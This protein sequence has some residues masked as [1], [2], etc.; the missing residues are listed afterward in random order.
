MSSALFRRLELRVRESRAALALR[1][2]PLAPRF[3]RRHGDWN[4]RPLTL[5]TEVLEGAG[6]SLRMIRVESVDAVQSTTMVFLPPRRSGHAIFVADLLSFAGVLGAVIL[7]VTPKGTTAPRPELASARLRLLESC[8]PRAFGDA[9]AAALFSTEAVFAKPRP[10]GGRQVVEAF[11]TYLAAFEQNVA[12][13]VSSDEAAASEDRFLKLL[14]S[15]KRQGLILSKLFGHDFVDEF[16]A[17]AF[18]APRV[19]RQPTEAA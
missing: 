2:V 13:R 15:V 3:A 7:D 1:P 11:E 5:T 19:V 6:M 9:D 8:T 18:C 4:G 16:F 17:E 10:D 12:V 14:S